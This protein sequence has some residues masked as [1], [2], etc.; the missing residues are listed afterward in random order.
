MPLGACTSAVSPSSLPISARAMGLGVLIRACFRSGSVSPPISWVTRSP[1]SS[2]SSCTVAPKT[3]L[4]PPSTSPG[5]ITCATESFPSIS[6]MRPSTKPWRSLAA[7]WSA[8]SLRSPCARASAIAVITDGR[9]TVLRW[10]SSCLSF[11]APRLVIGM[12]VIL[13]NL[14]GSRQQQC[15][16]VCIRGM[17]K[18]N[19]R[20]VAARRYSGSGADYAAFAGAQTSNCA[21]NCCTEYTS[22]WSRCCMPSTAAS[23]PEMGGVFGDFVDH[24]DG[25]ARCFDGRCRALGG[26]QFEAERDQL[27]GDVHRAR[28]VAVLHGEEHLARSGQLGACAE[29]A[30][31]EGC[32]KGFAHAHH[33]AGGLHLGA[34]DGVYAGEFDEREHGLLDAEV[35][36]RDLPGDALGG[37]RLAGHAARG[38][39][40]QRDARGLGDEGHGAR[41]AGVD[42]Q[43]VDHVLAVHFLDGELHVHQSDHVQ[44]LGHGG[45]LALEFVHRRP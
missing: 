31:D 15:Q 10:C 45:A 13:V 4:P 33:L 1:D 17:Q 24:F 29:L 22:S 40:G 41:G 3:T 43:H 19:R 36:R 27:A 9:S 7:S 37:Q 39:L 23:A 14:H 34:E 44:A 38:H 5:S 25:H 6:L 2:S 26:Q 16:D 12:V 42:L 35:G 21:C 11:S 8:F 32:A 20:T 28:L 30:L 18:A